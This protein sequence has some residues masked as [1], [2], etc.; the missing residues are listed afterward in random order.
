VDEE[1][2]ARAARHGRAGLDRRLSALKIDRSF[3]RDIAVDPDDEA[4]VRAVM[5]LAHT[6]KLAVVAEGIETD[7]QLAFL[8]DARCDEGQ[9]YLFCAQR[10]A[11]ELSALLAGDGT[12]DSRERSE[13]AG[14]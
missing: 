14:A 10:P 6:L 2:A 12:V 9:G 11:G 13:P 7:A 8:A 4:I 3:V 5:A 1:R